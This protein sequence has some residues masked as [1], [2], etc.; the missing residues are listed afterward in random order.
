MN[1]I[2][3]SIIEIPMGTKNKFEVNKKTGKIKLDRVLYSAL[4][5]PGEYG[6]VDETLSG[7]GDPLDILIISNYPTF[8]GCV[9]DA[10]VIGYLKV[11]DNNME[12]EKIIGVVDKDPR[13]NQIQNI[14][15]I[16][17]FKLI[18]IKDFFQ[19]YKNL[20]NIKVKAENFYSLEEALKIINNDKKR[21]KEINAN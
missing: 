10:R 9:V 21:Y 20:Q 3:E 1:N 4:S 17:E 8:P 13:F 5:Y 16:P 14:N 11:I 18:E 7:D 12:D 19:N 6:Y 2:F 15:D